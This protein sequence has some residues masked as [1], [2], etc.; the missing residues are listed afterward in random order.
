MIAHAIL[1]HT[2]LLEREWMGFLDSNP[3][4]PSADLEVPCPLI[5]DLASIPRD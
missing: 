3:L 1:S 2:T 5:A 4:F